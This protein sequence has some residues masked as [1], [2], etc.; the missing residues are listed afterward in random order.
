MKSYIYTYVYLFA[1]RRGKSLAQ[2]ECE[3]SQKGVRILRLNYPTKSQ[4]TSIDTEEKK[5][6]KNPRHGAFV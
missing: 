4:P 3:Y 6:G 1:D 2:A 5:R